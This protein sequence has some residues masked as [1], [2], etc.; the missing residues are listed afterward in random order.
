M[1]DVIQDKAVNESTLKRYDV[2]LRDWVTNKI[3]DV[4]LVQKVVLATIDTNE[5][6]ASKTVTKDIGISNQYDILV[7]VPSDD[8]TNAKNVSSSG[9][10][11]TEHNGTN[12][13]ITYL[14]SKPV[15]TVKLQIAA[16]IHE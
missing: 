5:W 7:S 11:V 12:I 13:T 3:S 6:S 8:I 9:I 14:N 4:K 2:R 15:T 1:A 10:F 16:L